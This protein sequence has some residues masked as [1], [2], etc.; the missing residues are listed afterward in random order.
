MPPIAY[1]GYSSVVLDRIMKKS[2]QRLFVSAHLIFLYCYTSAQDRVEY[3]TKYVEINKVST[4]DPKSFK[5]VF[6]PGIVNLEAPAPGGESYRSHLRKLKRDVRKRFPLQNNGAKNSL[7]EVLDE[8]V[9]LN[10]FALKT[11]LS[12]LDTSYYFSGGIPLDNTLAISNDNYLIC[13][14]NSKIYM[15]DL[16]TGNDP[17]TADISVVSFENFA[18]EDGVSTDGP[19]DPK[20]VYDPVEDKFIITFLTGR[21]PSNS[22]LILAFSTTNNPTDPWHVYEIPGNPLNNGLWSDYP[23]IALTQDELF[24]TI[25]LLVPGDD[26]KVSFSETVVWQIDKHSGYSGEDTLKSKL[27]GDISLDGRNLRNLAVVPGADGL[28][29]PNMYFLSNRNFDIENDTTF[30]VEITDKIDNTSTLTITPLIAAQKYGL[31]PNGRQSNS[32]PNDPE[33]GFDTNDARVLGAFL[34]EEE[35]QFVGNSVNPSTGLAAIYHGIISNV[36]TDPKLRANIIGSNQL[37]YGYPNIAYTGN[38]GCTSS[39]VIGF[40]HT[41]PVDFAGVSVV[42]YSRDSIGNDLY[43]ERMTLKSGENYV[44]KHGGSYERWGDYFGIQRKYNEPGVVYTAGFFGTSQSSISGTWFSELRDCDCFSIDVFQEI[45]S[46]YNPCV[47]NLVA[48]V[49]NGLDPITFSWNQSDT[50]SK[51]PVNLCDYTYSLQSKD[52]HCESIM[53]GEYSKPEPGKKNNIYPNPAN[54][55]VNIYFEVNKKSSVSVYIFNSEG[56]L[57][58][59][60]LDN[61]TTKEGMNLLSFSTAPLSPGMYILKLQEGDSEI[62]TKKLI[63]E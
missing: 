48:D 53:T 5:P 43:S 45:T 8:P 54:L 39:S 30:L 7:N 38:P 52:K 44:D 28:K 13:S 62:L 12:V 23:A 2:L 18:S 21:V 9:V 41:S 35:I 55:D 29:G 56:R 63:I 4:V 3:S 51:F 32:N 46:I 59:Q 47:G 26:W 16:K 14:I 11:Y 1:I 25:N 61:E 10:Q 49:N 34:S 31:P 40:D 20:L 37:D 22:G 24:Y 57:A 27:W 42:R 15:H 6:A 33:D 17:K 58:F 60:L 36:S 50:G 19:F